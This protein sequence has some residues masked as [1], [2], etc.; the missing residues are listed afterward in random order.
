MK[1]FE[2]FDKVYCI[3]L[4]RRYDRFLKFKQCIEKYDLGEFE[5]ISAVDGGYLNPRE[6]N[7]SLK[8]GELGLLLTN[9]KILLNAK[10]NNYSSILILEDDCTFTDDI[11]N[12]KNLLGF[13]PKDWDMYYMGGNHNT[14]M[15][16][17]IPPFVNERVIKI[18]NTY[19]THFVAIKN[20]IYDDVIS[21]IKMYKYPLD[22]AY[23]AIQKSKNV[24]CYYPGM[25]KQI[26]DFSDIQNMTTDYDWLIK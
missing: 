18:S 12:Y 26:S 4:D 25:A 2:N 15:G 24:Y 9:E 13:L 23:T 7:S 14:H 1:F 11:L 22:V 5:R 17:P 10:A 20:S 6:Y 19:S 21:L 3:N 8:N 16:L